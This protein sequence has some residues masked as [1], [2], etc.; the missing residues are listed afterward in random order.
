MSLIKI[1]LLISYCIT[2]I[3][4]INFSFSFSSLGFD[5]KN[6]EYFNNPYRV[7]GIAPWSSMKKIRKK[8]TELAKKLHPDKS[9][10]GSREEFEI[11][12][13]AF[14]RIKKERKESEEN[15]E[16]IS[17]SNV[18]RNT[19]S[20][21]LHIEIIFAIIYSFSYMIYKFQ[22]MIYV[23]LFYMVFSFTIITN[24]FPHFFKEELIEYI[25]CIIIGW[26]LYTRHKKYFRNKEKSDNI[27]KEI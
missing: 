18:I 8:Y 7:L 17:F 20:K 2:T 16:D 22:S 5:Y 13:R 27:N 6:I 25:A 10:T 21:V 11:V 14:E 23:P 19:V 12:Q 24:I 26:L 1:F 15:E 4:S 3:F 9:S